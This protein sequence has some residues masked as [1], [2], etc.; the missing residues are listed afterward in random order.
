MRWNGL[1]I[2]IGELSIAFFVVVHH[3]LP[4][5]VFV[6]VGDDLIAGEFRRVFDRH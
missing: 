6:Y 5:V 4:N 1:T 3:L 2:G